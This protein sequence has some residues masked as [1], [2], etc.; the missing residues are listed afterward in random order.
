M[1][2]YRYI[3]FTIKNYKNF[4]DNI[5]L[6][7]LID[8]LITDKQEC[9]YGTNIIVKWEKSTNPNKVSTTPLFLFS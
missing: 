6:L 8:K 3:V 5:Q 2:Q 9:I 7:N 4:D 1:Y